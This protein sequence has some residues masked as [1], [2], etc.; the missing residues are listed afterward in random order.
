MLPISIKTPW[1]DRAVEK[2]VDDAIATGRPKIKTSHMK[3]GPYNGYSGDLRDLADWKIKIA[4]ELELIPK[5]EPL[6]INSCNGNK[7]KLHKS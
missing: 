4:I 2:L 7:N 6:R 1:D 3:L 5:A